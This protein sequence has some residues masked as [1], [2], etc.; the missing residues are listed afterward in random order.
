MPK[1]DRAESEEY[2]KPLLGNINFSDTMQSA[3]ITIE[4]IEEIL[5][6]K[7][8]RIILIKGQ[9]GVGRTYITLR[10]L[11]KFNFDY[12]YYTIT[13]SEEK[14]QKLIDI[15]DLKE[16]LNKY[17]KVAY[18][19]SPD[20]SESSS[21]LI[22]LLIMTKFDEL[23]NNDNFIF[24][25]DDLDKMDKDIIGLF[26]NIASK[27]LKENAKARIIGIY[28][29]E[30]KNDDLLNV[31]SILKSLGAVELYMSYLDMNDFKKLIE[32][33][34]YTLPPK[35]IS[36]LYEKSEGKIK[37]AMDLIK[38]LEKQNFIVE[39]IFVKPVTENVINEIKKLIETPVNLDE[40]FEMIKDKEMLIL[41]YLAILNER[42]DPIE[43]MNIIKIGEDE[44]IDALDDLIKKGLIMESTDGIELKRKDLV[45]I[46]EKSFSSLRIRDVRLKIA[47]YYERNGRFF[48]AG[49]NYYY[50][51]NFEKA[52]EYLKRAGLEYSNEN[53]TSKALQALSFAY[54]IR[55]DDREVALN[56]LKIL[57]SIEDYEK[58]MNIAN[59]LYNRYP[60]DIEINIL[61]ATVM[62]RMNNPTISIEVYS[63]LENMELDD[64]S[65]V[66]IYI[67]L[68]ENYLA[69]YDLD[70]A[71][72]YLK[73]AHDVAEKLKDYMRLQKIFRLLGQ[74]YTE[75]DDIMKALEFLGMSEKINENLENYNDL[76]STYIRIAKIYSE[77]DLKKAMEY[78]NKIQNLTER[79]WI[80]RHL[81]N[82]YL[83]M[84][85]VYWYQGKVND[86][87]YL[88]R[89]GFGVSMLEG[90]Y[91]PAIIAAINFAD[92]FI[93][94]GNVFEAENYL[95]QSMDISLK[96]NK[97]LYSVELNTIL[98][99][100]E[101]LKGYEIDNIPELEIIMNTGLTQ[102]VD[103]AYA[104]MAKFELF[105]GNLRNSVENYK[106]LYESK[107]NG[108]IKASD[109]I[110]LMDFL[111]L[112]L[113]M[114]IIEKNQVDE[115]FLNVYQ[116]IRNMELIKSMDLL[117]WRFNIMDAIILYLKNRNF[118]I[119][120]KIN[121]YLRNL[122]KENLLLILI[123]Y[124]SII[125]ILNPE[126]FSMIDKIKNTIQNLNMEGLKKNFW[127]IFGNRIEIGQQKN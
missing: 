127:K 88:F 125:Y 77:I 68:G 123:R 31:I 64:Q 115:E 11:K 107:K 33:N 25:M 111:E 1:I 43:L 26:F 67:G 2:Q 40:I 118:K 86:A 9:E 19:I 32:E 98:K 71:E 102:Y 27:F 91:D 51:K 58:S 52:F 75:R 23:K 20:K 46:I 120:D 126:N 57:V 28:N 44:F 48:E 30:N 94:T 5:K 79:L 17:I 13:K 14:Y 62:F 110:D 78:Y 76:L 59:E 69:L 108:I 93:K 35:I 50:A 66:M 89:K 45:G 80:P 121:E 116:E 72:E 49:L 24:V 90:N 85:I 36:F 29:S 6:N 12:K 100:I 41:L 70:T 56:Y 42:I 65:R 7:N 122:E 37:E 87:I 10:I 92:I 3:P 96:N 60:D 104:T 73:K 117:V 82:L 34:G 74:I 113:E 53:N 15:L 18:A 84:S 95:K 16:S 21:N 109:L 39:K 54:E 22:N 83:N 38:K 114:E 63:K 112:F 4:N 99:L 105:R 106:K 101:I 119:E 103:F 8:Y 47:S 124:F 61:Y 97:K 55:K 81:Q